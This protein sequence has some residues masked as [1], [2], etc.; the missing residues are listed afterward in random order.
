MYIFMPF[1]RVLF[2]FIF[3]AFAFVF[4]QLSMHVQCIQDIV[5]YY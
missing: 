1:V 5:I 2:Y 4:I 3:F